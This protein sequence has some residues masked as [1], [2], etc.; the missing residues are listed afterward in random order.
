[1]TKQF[2]LAALMASTLL[3]TGP[4]LAGGWMA[5]PQSID[6]S[7]RAGSREAIVAPGTK[8]QIAGRRMQPGQTVQVMRGTEMLTPEPVTVDE[9]GSFK[10]EFDIPADAEAGLHPLTVIAANPAGIELIDLKL[11]KEVPVSGQDAFQMTAAATGE[12][13]YH[14]ALSDDGKLFVA[15]ARGESGPA[16][17]RLDAASMAE[18]ARAEI[19]KDAEGKPM[20]VFGLDVDDK[21]GNV[22]TSDTLNNTVVVYGPDLKPLKV[23]DIDAISHPRDVIVDEAAGRVYVNAALTGKVHVFDAATMDELAS[24]MMTAPTGRDAFG[25][26]SLA[27]DAKGGKLYSVS[28]ANPFV[29]WVD[30]NSG[31]AGAWEVDGLASASGIARDA[32]TG[33]LYVASQDSNNLVVLDE[34]GEKL[35][36]TM[37]G[38]GALSVAFDAA[39]KQAYVASRGAGTLTVTDADGKIVANLPLGDLPNHVVTDGK[40]AVFAVSMLGAPGDDDNTGSVTKVTAK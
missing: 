30:V 23:F 33:R 16:L 21:T 5:S 19:A 22:W 17:V 37:V 38:A 28:R 26:M 31:E 18:E 7:I 35:A 6:G 1:M 10:V 8:T 27:L 36:D 14:A 11:S 40:G 24:L 25:T 4:A 13:S 34:K 9:K 3:I 29:G 32:E 20:G 12:R 2:R 39:T 15:A